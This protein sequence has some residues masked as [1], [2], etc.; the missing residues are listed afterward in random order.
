MHKVRVVAADKD[1]LRSFQGEANSYFSSTVED[2][3]L[4]P[5]PIPQ[6]S[7]LSSTFVAAESAS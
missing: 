2:S 4:V 7:F 5:G 1:S 3:G 6:K